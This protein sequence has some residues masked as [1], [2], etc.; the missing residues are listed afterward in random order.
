M[1]VGGGAVFWPR[2]G[3]VEGPNLLNVRGVWSL[4]APLWSGC[5]CSAPVIWA[6]PLRL[7][8]LSLARHGI[9]QSDFF[10]LSSFVAAYFLIAACTGWVLH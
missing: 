10:F 7:P 6:C 8:F 4:A 2:N 1:L 9:F 5:A 3:E